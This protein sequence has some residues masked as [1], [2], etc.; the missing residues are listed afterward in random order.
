MATKRM[1]SD[2]ILD[3]DSF[4]DMPTDAQML[5]IRLNMAADD[6]GIVSNPRKVMRAYNFSDDCMKILVSKKFVLVRTRDEDGCTVVIIKHWKMH[7]TIKNDRFKE[8][9]FVDFL[10]GV[11][12][13]ENK[14]YSLTP[15]KGKTPVL[16][17][18]QI[19][20]NLLEPEWNQNGTRMEPKN[21]LD[22]NRLDL[23][24][25]STSKDSTENNKTSFYLSDADEKISEIMSFYLDAIDSE[26][27]PSHID[28]IK[29][30]I[31]SRGADKVLAALKKC[32]ETGKTSFPW[33]VKAVNES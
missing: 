15:G 21:R 12:Y 19:S 5:Y 14:A 3:S 9:P 11:F 2:Q 33:I 24:E 23:E 4:S 22:K 20:E 17:A 25:I 7:N 26:P 16:S 32:V 1:F 29:A 6:R 31:Q 13:D 30:S 27:C 8:S 18:K 10:N 28:F